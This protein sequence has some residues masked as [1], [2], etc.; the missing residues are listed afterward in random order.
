MLE[1]EIIESNIVEGG[2]EI[3][4]RA[5]QDGVQIGFGKDGTVDIERFRIINPPVLVADPNGDIVEQSVSFITGETITQTF[6]EDPEEATLQVL[7]HNIGILKNK[8]VGSKVIET[9]KRGNTTT[10]VYPSLD[11][12]VG[13]RNASYATTRAGADLFRD[14]TSAYIA[15]YVGVGQYRDSRYQIDRGWVIFDTSSISASDTL[16]SAVVSFTA[17]DVQNSR[18]SG[19]DYVT[20]V[21]S[22]LNSTSDITTSDWGNIGGVAGANTIDY[23]SITANNSTYYDFTL[24]ATGEAWV[25]FGGNTELGIR[26]GDDIAN[27]NASLTTNQ[28]NRVIFNSVRDSG[29]AI[30]PKLVIEHTAGAGGGYRYVPQLTPFA[31]L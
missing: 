17:Q 15:A 29:T 24:N 14:K 12:S 13:S 19:T 16:D 28:G 25:V 10:T 3:F 30:D 6:R 7:E 1:I 5:W 11:G 2:V 26:G 4:A 21:E 18:N 31:G 27:T 23:S 22:T 9:G 20:I 8:V